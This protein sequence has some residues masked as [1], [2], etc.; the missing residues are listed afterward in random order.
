[1]FEGLIEGRGE[2]TRDGMAK[3]LQFGFTISQGF[4]AILDAVAI[5]GAFGTAEK[6]AAHPQPLSAPAVRMAKIPCGSRK[7][8]VLPFGAA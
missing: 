8:G 4:C 5:C 2:R 1:M 3:D 7:T 6:G